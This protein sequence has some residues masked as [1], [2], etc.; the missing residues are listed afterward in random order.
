M[1]FQDPYSSL[2]PQWRVGAA[3]AEALRY[4]GGQGDVAELLRMVALDP[5]DGEKYP[6]QFSGGQR[7]RIAIARAIA[8]APELLICD[9]PTSALDVSVQAQII[10]L[11]LDLQ[12]KQGLTYLFI[13]HN[14]SDRKSTRLNSSHT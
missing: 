5:R 11:L 4:G 6:H 2:N 8:A 13:S 12:A 1:V 10:N 14:L 3:I 9:E 7:Q